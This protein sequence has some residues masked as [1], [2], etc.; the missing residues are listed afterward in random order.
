MSIGS[1]C[2]VLL[3]QLRLLDCPPALE[4]SVNR[5]HFC[6][7][8]NCAA[9]PFQCNFTI[10]DSMAHSSGTVGDV[11]RLLMSLFKCQSQEAKQ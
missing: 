3:K 1:N 11:A 2:G 6:L 10:P 9:L 5:M 7:W 4:A 8:G